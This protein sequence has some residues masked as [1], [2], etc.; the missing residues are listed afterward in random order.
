MILDSQG[1][2]TLHVPHDE[3]MELAKLA[4]ELLHE[5]GQQMNAA[6]RLSRDGQVRI[7]VGPVIKAIEKAYELGRQKRV[8]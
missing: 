5:V 2:P 1:R 7:S 6:M 4:K 3:Q 8:E